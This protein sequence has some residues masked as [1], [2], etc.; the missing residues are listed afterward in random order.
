MK[1]KERVRKAHRQSKVNFDHEQYKKLRRDG[2]KELEVTRKTFYT[3]RIYCPLKRGNFRPFF[4][5]LKADKN[6]RREQLVLKD[7]QN[8]VTGDPVQCA[9][10]LNTFFQN[11]FQL[12]LMSE[13][14]SRVETDAQASID[15]TPEGVT[16]Q[17]KICQMENRQDLMEFES[18][19]CS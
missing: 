16:K 9:E 10:L 17:F 6:K 15:V 7:D 12:G 18:L 5:L 4:K 13:D 14:F 19:T 1:I 8:I 2:K 3:N 11:Q